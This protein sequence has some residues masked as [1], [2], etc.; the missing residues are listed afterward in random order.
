MTKKVELSLAAALV[1]LLC[2]CLP[3][4]SK[5]YKLYYLGGQSNMDGF[6]YVKELP[7]ALQSTQSKVMIFHGNLAEDNHPPDGR[8][9]WTQ[10]RPGHGAGFSSDGTV[11]SYSDRFGIELTFARRLQ[12]LDPAANIALLKYSRGGTSI[13][14]EAAGDFGCWDPDF[15]GT[16]EGY[17]QYDHF[18][19]TVE[20]A[21]SVRDIDGDGEEDNLI[22]AGI[23]WM[24]GESDA[25]YGKAIASRYEANLK[26]L[27][28][29]IRA[30]LRSDNLP[31]VIG[32]IS[33]S[34]QDDDGKVWDYGEIV[35]LAQQMFVEKD[36]S[37]ALV[38]STDKYGYSDPWHYDS[39]GYIDLGQKFAEAMQDLE[40]A[41]F[42]SNWTL[43]WSD[44]FDY[45]GLPDS[46]KW[47]YDTGYIA[48]NEKQ[49]YLAEREENA[50][51]EGGML[52]IE[53]RKEAREGFDY[54]SARL[55]TDG[56]A[57]WLYGRVEVS[58][59]LPTGRGM[60]PAIWMLGSNCSTVGWPECGEIDIMENVGFEPEMVHSNIHTKAYNHIL[61]TDRAHHLKVDAPS[62]NF[63][64]YS[65]EWFEDRIEFLVDDI[66]YF[67]FRNEGTGTDTWPFAQPHYLILNAAVGGVWGG[68]NGIDDTI[69]P[70]KFYIDYVRVYERR[71]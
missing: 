38:T 11:N 66:L 22:P 70:Q 46:S 27:M 34:G 16:P 58:A 64:V 42:A 28:D 17:N 60:W 50:R 61:R 23:V 32:R 36:R 35:R 21:L 5:D 63:Y 47:N 24:Q 19:A 65:I 6:G 1:I 8:G 29:L 20:S 41:R 57:S 33:D 15:E 3:A 4:F 2:L 14:I 26:R 12:A 25:A 51:V 62:E 44:E 18:L 53:A 48:N 59:K 39:P 56:K 31:V 10:L 43:I 52:V 69:F 40:A 37:A 7:E 30:A 67:T 55:K 54:T 68:R 49:Y 13:A 45:Q 71:E 9:I